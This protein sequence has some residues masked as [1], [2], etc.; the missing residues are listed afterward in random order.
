MT[1]TRRQAI[2]TLAGAAAASGFGAGRAAAQSADLSFW[3]WRQEDRTQYAQLWGDFAKE[4]PGIKVG[5]QGYEPQ[6]YGTV[7]STAL[8]AGKG[9]DV[10]HVRAYGGTEQF[11]KAGY[12]LPLT[13]DLVPE[14]AN[15]PDAALRSTSLRADNRSTP[16]PSP[17]RR[18][19][20]SST[21]RSST[22]WGCR[23][24]KPGTSSSRRPRP[25]RT[26]A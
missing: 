16:S 3:T 23:C 17:P 6:S 26:R 4:N 10:I 15:I 13:R 21:A 1:I 22:A 12:L 19:A 25:P 18:S 5:F 8:A 11:A 9:P 7:L 2:H 20:S 24:R 14:L